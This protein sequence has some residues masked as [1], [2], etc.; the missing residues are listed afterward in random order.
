MNPTVIQNIIW[1]RFCMEQH[2]PAHTV[3]KRMTRWVLSLL[4]AFL[5]SLYCSQSHRILWL[6]LAP[7]LFQ[8]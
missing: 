2:L 5:G 6:Y 1:K 8:A 3:Q 4:P 7:Q